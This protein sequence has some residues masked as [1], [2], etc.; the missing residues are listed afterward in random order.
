M[1]ASDIMKGLITGG[2]PL[3][4]YMRDWGLGE[5]VKHGAERASL[6]GVAG[7]GPSLNPLDAMGP[8]VSQISDAVK[9]TLMDP[10]SI[11]DTLHA[12]SPART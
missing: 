11:G 10:S 4:D 12:R 1:V 3:P 5:R 6:T 7:L 9:H 8:T 2:G